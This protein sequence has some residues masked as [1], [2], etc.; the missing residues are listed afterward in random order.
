MDRLCVEAGR[1]GAGSIEEK[2]LQF[3]QKLFIG[4]I[5]GRGVG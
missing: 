4:L 2:S 5:G 3:Y 1:G